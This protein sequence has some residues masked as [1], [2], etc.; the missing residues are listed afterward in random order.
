MVNILQQFMQIQATTNNQNTQAIN[1]LRGTIN[2]INTT[3]STQ[4]K[5]KFLAQPQPNPQVYR[6]QQQQVHNV[7][8]EIFETAKAVLTLRSGKEVPQPEM[9]MDTQV[10]APTPVD[11]TEIDETEKESE[12]VRPESKKPVS[13]DDETMKRK[14]NVKKKA[15]LTEQVS[16]L[17]L[18]ETLQKFGDLC[19][20]HISIIIGESR[21]RRAL[22]DLGSSINLLPFSEYEQLGLGELKKTF[23]K[24]QLVDRSLKQPTTTIYQTPVI[25]GRPFLTT[26]NALINY[27]SR[28]LKLTFRNMTLEMN[29][30]NTFKMSSDC[31][32]S[33]VHAVDV[34][35]EL[36]EIKREAYDNSRLTGRSMTN[37]LFLIRKCSS[38]IQDCIFFP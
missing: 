21:I 14:L 17:I 19:S 7:S 23:I 13:A 15:F 5:G 34:I 2:K 8:G 31:D 12:L 27:R 9:T 38:T 26:S 1:D 20:P 33:E 18:S 22:L 6:Q 3:L 37:I 30:F 25:L 28:V 32:E 16:A 10:V 4:E 24:L 35:S 11:A 36:D 29:V